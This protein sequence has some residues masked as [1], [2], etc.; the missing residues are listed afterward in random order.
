MQPE[1]RTAALRIRDTHC[2]RASVSDLEHSWYFRLDWLRETSG[3]GTWL[4][5]REVQ[6]ASPH[7]V[8]PHLSGAEQAR[9]Q[10]A[11]GQE[12][13]KGVSCGGS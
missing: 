6:L 11:R 8:G 3:P 4:G 12:L 2:P 10:E 1:L 7:A 13:G 9:G 5:G